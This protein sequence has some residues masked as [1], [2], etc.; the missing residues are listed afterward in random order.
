MYPSNNSSFFFDIVPN[1]TGSGAIIPKNRANLNTQVYNITYITYILQRFDIVARGIDIGTTERI[2]WKFSPIEQKVCSPSRKT[3]LQ[4][5]EFRVTER[6]YQLCRY[7]PGLSFTTALTQAARCPLKRT[8]VESCSHYRCQATTSQ[9][10][11]WS[12]LRLWTRNATAD[13]NRREVLVSKTLFF[14][15]LSSARF[16][17]ALDKPIKA[18]GD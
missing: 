2:L 10:R 5:H 3:Y 12:I 13:F 16:T 7:Q 15:L 8:P 18:N 14:S 6:N 4:F 11:A 9:L 17:M 1:Y